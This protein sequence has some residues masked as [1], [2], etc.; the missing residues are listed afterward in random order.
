MHA[1]AGW[2]KWPA[3]PCHLIR[4]TNQSMPSRA[5]D[6]FIWQP[7]AAGSMHETRHIIIGSTTNPYDATKKSETCSFGSSWSPNHG[8]PGVL[9]LAYL[10]CTKRAKQ[11][12]AHVRVVAHCNWSGHHRRWLR[13]VLPVVAAHK[14][15]GP[16]SMRSLTL[17]ASAPRTP[18]GWDAVETRIIRF[19]GATTRQ[20][21][22][23]ILP[24]KEITTQHGDTDG[25]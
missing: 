7:P 10:G 22:N 1:L 20:G 4:K 23:A 11:T 6:H 2:H 24:S 19:R 18:G 21:H 8:R 14:F 9:L 25:H 3:E 16:Y 13:A 15:S 12:N 5:H 17:L